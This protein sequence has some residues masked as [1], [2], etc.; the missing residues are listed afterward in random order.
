MRPVLIAPGAF[1]D[2]RASQVAAA[3]GRGLERCGFS[4]DLCPAS[5]GGPGTLE[6]LLVALGGEALADGFALVEDGHTAIA[7]TPAALRA[8]LAGEAPVVVYAGEDGD[9]G[10][11]GGDP[12]VLR[13]SAPFVLD[14][15]GFDARMRAARAV[16][17]GA[18]VIG[19]RDLRGTLIAEVATRARQS[20]VPCFAI[21]GV[22]ELDLFGARVLDLQAIEVAGTLAEIERAAVALAELLPRA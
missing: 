7:E 3:I 9:G 11:G 2:L 16:I 20:G 19:A 4:V 1:G 21:T 6:T 17:T 5:D 15:L 13:A 12:R 18:G 10:G 22:N 8:A 14:A